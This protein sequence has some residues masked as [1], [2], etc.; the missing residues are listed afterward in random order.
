MPGFN[1]FRSAGY[2]V[3]SRITHIPGTTGET[4]TKGEAVKVASGAFTKAGPTDAIAGFAAQTKTISA[5]DTALEVTEARADD[6]FEVTYTGTP[7]AGFVMGA[8]AAAVSTDGLNSDSTTVAGGALAVVSI[9]T[10]K[11]TCRVRVK[12]RQFS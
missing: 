2:E 10:T 11:K 6:V 5:N 9:N 4:F 3:P 1:W 8:N 12:N 7:V